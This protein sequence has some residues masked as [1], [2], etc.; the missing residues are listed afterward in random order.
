MFSTF[1]VGQES[2]NI[3]ISGIIKDL[4]TKMPLVAK[5]EII[6]TDLQYDSQEVTTKTDGSFEVKVLPKQLILHVK[7]DN[8]IV[9]NV[10][11]NL[12]SL[13][14]PSV[15]TEIYLIF[16][17]KK[18]INQMLLE[19]ASLKNETEKKIKKNKQVF[20]AIDA[21]DGKSIAAQ[22][23]LI[24]SIKNEICNTKTSDETPVFEYNFT[25]KDN[26]L[27]E[28]TAD[29][30]QKI[31]SDILIED[32]DEIV[33][34]NTAKLIK[35]IAFINLLLLN[36]NGVKPNNVNVFEINS[37]GLKPIELSKKGDLYF[38]MLTLGSS[39]KIAINSKK[40]G[41]ITKEFVAI[42][43][44]N[45]VVIEIETKNPEIIAQVAPK[46]FTE[47]ETKVVQIEKQNF[48]PEKKEVNLEVQTIFFEQSSTVLNKNS[49]EML[50]EISKKML[51]SP[52]LK[53][54]ITGHTDNIGDTRQNLYLS[55]FRAKVICNFLF[56]KGIKMDRI[57]PKGNGSKEPSSTNETEENRQKN[58][59][60]ELRFY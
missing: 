55:E 19:F 40:S 41:E 20:Q 27:L 53:I 10:L 32:F 13:T 49:K 48:V 35:K 30:Y 24:G 38:G 18:K 17:S 52:E 1:A 56:N 2:K 16:D 59:R 37:N 11:M 44:V 60:A 23:R 45:Q 21:I 34:E 36:K 54:E 12:N 8:Y 29:S 43:G 3:T 31:W 9:S 51:E 57:L 46:A 26:V 58:R 47:I 5:I 15:Q 50:E 25:K 42:E 6:Y 28:V 39:Y 14:A 33:H 22:F 4:K 7:T